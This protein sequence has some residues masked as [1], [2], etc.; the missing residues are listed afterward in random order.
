MNASHHT[1]IE[2]QALIQ[3]LF[4][5]GHLVSGSSLFYRLVSITY[6]QYLLTMSFFNVSARANVVIKS[7][8][9]MSIN[10]E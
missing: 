8:F 10:A 7:S 3:H 9:S 5:R 6:G 2:L 1:L 4:C